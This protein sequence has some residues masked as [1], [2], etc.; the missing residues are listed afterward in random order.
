[1]PNSLEYMHKIF[2]CCLLE[3]LC[4]TASNILY[5][6]SMFYSNADIFYLSLIGIMETIYLI[7]CTQILFTEKE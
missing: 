1:M 2:K 3:N 4:N 5:L 7:L 6:L